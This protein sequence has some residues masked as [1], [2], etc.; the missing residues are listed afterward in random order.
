[1]TIQT[2]MTMIMIMFKLFKLF[3]LFT[4]LRMVDKLSL[5][6][7]LTYISGAL[8]ATSIMHLKILI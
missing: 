1:M 8:D 5:S 6:Q 4:L 7:S 3:I 2:I